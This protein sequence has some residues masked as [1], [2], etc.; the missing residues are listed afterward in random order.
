MFKNE[1]FNFKIIMYNRGNIF[2][3][4]SDYW[5]NIKKSQFFTIY[6]VIQSAVKF[7]LYLHVHGQ[8]SDHCQRNTYIKN[9]AH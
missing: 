8:S 6:C 1:T 2:R 9:M 7:I 4:S 3:Y 5:N